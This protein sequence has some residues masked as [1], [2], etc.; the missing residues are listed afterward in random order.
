MAQRKLK[1]ITETLLQSL[2]INPK[3]IAHFKEI[4]RNLENRIFPDK[5]QIKI[6]LQIDDNSERIHLSKKIIKRMCFDSNYPPPSKLLL[7]L[8]DAEEDSA[9]KAMNKSYIPQDHFVHALNLY[10]L[11][12]YV[13]F[14]HPT[15]NKSLTNYFCNTREKERVKNKNLTSTKDFLSCWKYFCLF[16]DLCYPI[17]IMYKKDIKPQ[18][19]HFKNYLS[20]FNFI[21][22]MLYREF[23]AE[24]VAK[25]YVTSQLTEDHNNKKASDLFKNLNY[26]FIHIPDGQPSYPE[27]EYKDF[28]GVDKLFVFDHF[29]IM[30]NFVPEDHVLLTVLLNVATGTPIG[31]MECD[32][33]GGN[34]KF[35]KRDQF[36]EMS[37]DQ[38][39]YMLTDDDHQFGS[40][41]RIMYFINKIDSNTVMSEMLDSCDITMDKWPIVKEIIGKEEEKKCRDYDHISFLRIENS[42]GFGRYLFQIYEIVGEKFG[43]IFHSTKKELYFIPPRYRSAFSVYPENVK[44]IYGKY[45]NNEFAKTLADSIAE[46]FKGSIK[47]GVVSDIAK[48]IHKIDDEKEISNTLYEELKKRFEENGILDSILKKT[49][50]KASNDMS[51]YLISEI[52]GT[53]A[54]TDVFSNIAK[55]LKLTSNYPNY[56]NESDVDTKSFFNFLNGKQEISDIVKLINENIIE[57]TSLSL[58]DLITKYENTNIRYDHGLCSCLYYLFCNTISFDVINN[59]LSDA[60]KLKFLVWD[61]D[62]SSHKTKLIEKY[63]FIVRQTAYSILCH[64]IHSDHFRKSFNYDW[65]IKKNDT[66]AYFCSLM[67][68]LQMWDRQKYVKHSELSWHPDFSYSNYNIY[69][70]DDQL[71]IQFLS[72]IRNFEELKKEKIDTLNTFLENCTDYIKMTVIAE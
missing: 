63:K 2:F 44:R 33:K 65:N 55:K 66:F 59:E 69:V 20:K 10:L 31:F 6:F 14:Y 45:M 3:P 40:Q 30:L 8:I 24:I 52:E 19:V 51:N 43:E 5:E 61:A 41:Y 67:D 25:L 23:L 29:K 60:S 12:I 4:Y 71:V 37:K 64:N 50:N 68:S 16:H 11:G 70:K 17:E 72:R 1:N 39:E 47:G 48:K 57:K 49:S 36:C 35:F 7:N 58:F 62:R 21:P 22:D 42:Q 38:L 15:L 13:Y 46:H 9:N 34:R 53:N 32:A 27:D 26:S 28:T 56:V 18:E 54:L